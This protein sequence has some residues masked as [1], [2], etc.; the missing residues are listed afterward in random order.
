VTN[1]EH[2]RYI[3]YAF[4]GNAGFYLLIL[5][6]MF[7]MF[8]VVFRNGEPGPPPEFSWI[9]MTFMSVFYGIFMLPSIIAGYGLL[10]RKSWARVASTVAAAVAGM[11]FPI[12]TG[13]CVYALWFFFSENW[14][15]IYSEQA[16]GSERRQIAYGVESQ[17]AAYEQAEREPRFD[18][19]HPPDWR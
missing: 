13:A 12:G 17:R 18:P 8:Y 19:Y 9:M 7:A 1:E 14:K 5:G 4:F 15:E 3:A 10:K 6:F 16:L 2:N 11:N